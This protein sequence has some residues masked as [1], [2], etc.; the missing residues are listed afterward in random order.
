M[1]EEMK[2]AAYQ[3]EMNGVLGKW[4]SSVKLLQKAMRETDSMNPARGRAWKEVM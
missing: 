4:S 3:K 1:E 2:E